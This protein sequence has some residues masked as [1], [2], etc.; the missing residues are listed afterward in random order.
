MSTVARDLPGGVVARNEAFI[1]KVVD[2]LSPRGEVVTPAALRDR[3][4]TQRDTAV[5]I[6]TLLNSLS[7]PDK[8]MNLAENITDALKRIQAGMHPHSVVQLYEVLGLI[9]NDSGILDPAIATALREAGKDPDYMQAVLTNLR[10]NREQMYSKVIDDEEFRASLD[11]RIKHSLDGAKTVD[12]QKVVATQILAQGYELV[13]DA[14]REG[15]TEVTEMY[16]GAADVKAK[17]VEVGL[18]LLFTALSVVNASGIATLAALGLDAAHNH[19]TEEAFALALSG[20]VTLSAIQSTKLGDPM[21]R[22]REATL[23]APVG[24]AGAALIGLGAITVDAASCLHG[25]KQKHGHIIKEYSEKEVTDYVDSLVERLIENFAKIYHDLYPYTSHEVAEKVVETLRRDKDKLHRVFEDT[26]VGS[27]PS[28]ISAFTEKLTADIDAEI[29]HTSIV[30]MDKTIH[31]LISLTPGVKETAQEAIKLYAMSS[32]FSK[33]KI[34]SMLARQRKVPENPLKTMGDWD[35]VREAFAGGKL[36]VDTADSTKVIRGKLVCSFPELRGDYQDRFAYAKALPAKT[37]PHKRQRCRSLRE[38]WV[39]AQGQLNAYISSKEL[40]SPSSLTI[41]HWKELLTQSMDSNLHQVQSHGFTNKSVIYSVTPATLV[42]ASP[43]YRETFK[44]TIAAYK[45]YR[46]QWEFIRT[47]TPESK[48]VDAEIKLHKKLEDGGINIQADLTTTLD[49]MQADLNSL[50]DEMVAYNTGCI[51][52]LV[53]CDNPE[54]ATMLVNLMSDQIVLL[55]QIDPAKAE[56]SLEKI[57]QSMMGRMNKGNAPSVMKDLKNLLT[58]LTQE[59]I[60]LNEGSKDRLATIINV[61]M[62]QAKVASDELFKLPAG[63]VGRLGILDTDKASRIPSVTS[64]TSLLDAAA[65]SP[66]ASGTGLLADGAASALTGRSPVSEVLVADQDG[67]AISPVSD[68][69]STVA[70]GSSGVEGLAGGPDGL[71]TGA[72]SVASSPARSLESSPARSPEP[73]VGDTAVGVARTARPEAGHMDAGRPLTRRA[74][75]GAAPSISKDLK[76]QPPS[77]RPAHR[78]AFSAPSVGLSQRRDVRRPS[79]PGASSSQLAAASHSSA[80]R[81]SKDPTAIT[82]RMKQRVKADR[83]DEASTADAGKKPGF[84]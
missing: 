16:E 71:T 46:A 76:K 34:D 64:S 8:L 4:L 21:T 31:S 47:I 73:L 13:G 54:L 29:R 36:D 35:K 43:V 65:V 58:V 37:H 27:T 14:F 44:Q 80:G 69:S 20:G 59:N 48:R 23:V 11:T 68:A 49:T 2:H 82:H 50:S 78:V 61:A 33:G 56:Q 6:V 26:L 62:T 53:T 22:T 57:I 75:H 45:D 63:V 70:S 7:N 1:A 79:D 39:T 42:V 77:G 60:K 17:R 55:N 72:S 81:A 15:L 12:V 41:E 66:S 30:H 38:G 74:A 10:D 25:L 28:V 84:K 18:A 5:M 51:A 32:V 40:L 19:A 52:K 67:P 3:K 83:S 9:T 24:G